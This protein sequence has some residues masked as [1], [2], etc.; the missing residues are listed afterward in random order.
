LATRKRITKRQLK[1]DQFV[2]RAFQ[3]LDY[4]QGNRSQ[5]LLVAG[6]VIAILLVATL[7]IRFQASS[8]RASASMLSAG[9]GYFQAG[10]YDE[11]TMRLSN[12]LDA[13][14]RHSDA[15]YASLVCGDAYYYLGSH[16]A[17]EE[18]Y[19]FCLEKAT[20][21]DADWIAASSGLAAIDEALGKPL[22]A[23]EAYSALAGRTEDLKV[24]THFLYSAVRC[25]REASDYTRA[26]ELLAQVD[27][28]NLDPIDA[29]SYEWQKREIEMAVGSNTGTP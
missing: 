8:K 10:Q 2:T 29:A 17:A 23:A 19:R 26:A 24:K 21:G 4:F 20:E 18:K 12:F 25:F 14:S 13:Y 27:E 15:G 9:I 1:E 16:D 7:G 6:G 28:A 22:S 11:A 3:F 5:V